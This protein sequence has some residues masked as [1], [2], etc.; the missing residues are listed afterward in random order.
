MRVELSQEEIKQRLV[1]LTNLER[2]YPRAKKKIV[3]LEKENR[4]LKARVKELED[5]DRDKGEKIEALS[6]QFEQLKNKLFGKKPIVQQVVRIREKKHRDIFSY[7]RPVPTTTK[8][9]EH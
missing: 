4:Q 7:R 5:K 2:I 1:R 6:F 3:F 9:S 8:L